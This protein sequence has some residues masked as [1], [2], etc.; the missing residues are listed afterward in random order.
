MAQQTRTV[1]LT[2]FVLQTQ[3]ISECMYVYHKFHGTSLKE[4]L[5][6]LQRAHL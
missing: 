2:A 4:F 6:M 3:Q 5:G 1:F